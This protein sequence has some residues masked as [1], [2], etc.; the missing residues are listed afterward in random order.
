MVVGLKK[1]KVDR[2]GRSSHIDFFW[3]QAS[4]LADSATNSRHS[5][6]HFGLIDSNE[7]IKCMLVIATGKVM[8]MKLAHPTLSRNNFDGFHANESAFSAMM[9][10]K[11]VASDHTLNL[12]ILVATEHWQQSL[13]CLASRD[14]AWDKHLNDESWD[15]NCFLSEMISEWLDWTRRK[16]HLRDKEQ[17][18]KSQRHLL[19]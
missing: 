6:E 1:V 19:C 8:L 11:A 7:S 4:S 3:A 17:A 5:G 14:V 9:R 10:V 13:A 2:R 15:L 12:I 18:L 16:Q